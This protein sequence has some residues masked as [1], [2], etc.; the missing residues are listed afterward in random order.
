[1]DELCDAGQVLRARSS[2]A[3]DLRTA[4]R[5]MLRTHS[6]GA[7]WSISSAIQLTH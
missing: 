5:P 6:F 2:G 3:R 1:V 7:I 4:A